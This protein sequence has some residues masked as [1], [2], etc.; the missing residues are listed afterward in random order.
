MKILCPKCKNEFDW[1]KPSASAQIT[2]VRG[3]NDSPKTYVK[4][5]PVCN[6]QLRIKVNK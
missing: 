2:A 3:N 4:A 5:C 6:A 1:N